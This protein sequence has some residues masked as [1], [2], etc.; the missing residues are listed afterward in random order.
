MALEKEGD[1]RAVQFA[2]DGFT[3][4]GFVLM[5]NFFFCALTE[6]FCNLKN[7]ILLKESL[8][9]CGLGSFLVYFL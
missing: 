8:K 5:V 1:Y 2:K 9:Y 7:G 3:K 4:D 6:L